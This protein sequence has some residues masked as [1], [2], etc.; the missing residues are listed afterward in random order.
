MD[1]HPPPLLQPAT[2]P[3][4]RP[5]TVEDLWAME[6]LGAPSLSPDGAQAVLPV[7][8][9]SMDDN[10]ASNALWLLS[11]LGG[12]PRQLTQCGDKD[13]APQFSPGATAWASPP[14]ASSRAARTR[15]RSSM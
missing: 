6:R 2:M 1:A 13:G 9:Y 8:R 7:T 15:P 3:K 4:R 10:K 12:Q 11:T 5:I 14:G